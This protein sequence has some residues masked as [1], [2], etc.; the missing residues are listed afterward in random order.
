M[1]FGNFLNIC[2][3]DTPPPQ[4][5]TFLNSHRKGNIFATSLKIKPIMII[6]INF[7]GFWTVFGDIVNFMFRSTLWFRGLSAYIA[8]PGWRRKMFWSKV[9][10]FRQSKVDFDIGRLLY[11]NYHML[12]IFSRYPYQRC[13]FSQNT[14]YYPCIILTSSPVTL[15]ACVTIKRKLS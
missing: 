7:M 4:K 15:E 8:W 10:F 11:K 6:S 14:T 5:N 3:K 9:I 2:I 12:I 1:E 13:I